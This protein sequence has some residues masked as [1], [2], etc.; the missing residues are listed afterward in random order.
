MTKTA[1]VSVHSADVSPGEGGQTGLQDAQ[2]RREDL[3]T[4]VPQ[5]GLAHYALTI[6]PACAAGFSGTGVRQAPR[7]RMSGLD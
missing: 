3:T 7:P 2:V 6:S 1:G 4:E 5:E